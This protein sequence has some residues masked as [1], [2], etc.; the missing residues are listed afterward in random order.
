MGTVRHIHIAHQASQPMRALPQAAIRAGQ[1]MVG[2]RYANKIGRYSG[3][4]KPGRHITMIEEEVIE[5]I[6]RTRGYLLAL[7]KADAT[8]PRAVYA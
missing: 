1:G 5:A 4:P 7:M 2:D 6:A 8:S 3:D